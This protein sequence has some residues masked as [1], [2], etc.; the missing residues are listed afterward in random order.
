[1]KFLLLSFLL[2]SSLLSSA[3]LTIQERVS[4]IQKEKAEVQKE[5]ERIEQ[6]E[7]YRI[8]LQALE[9]IIFEEKVWMKSYASYLTSCLLYTSPSPRD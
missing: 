8:E 4:L 5:S 1:M 3:E 2:L 6:I 9:Q 7:R